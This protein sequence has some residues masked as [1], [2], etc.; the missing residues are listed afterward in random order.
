MAS[1]IK[2]HV[3]PVVILPHHLD[4]PD[5]SEATDTLIDLSF[6][7]Y[8]IFSILILVLKWTFNLKIFFNLQ[9][10]KEKS[11]ETSSVWS[12]QTEACNGTTSFSLDLKF[13]FNFNLAS[14]NQFLISFYFIFLKKRKC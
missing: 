13:D 8:V 7:N 11:D 6:P 14:N 3:T 2:S 1:D 4:S 12:M 10:D 5:G 9:D